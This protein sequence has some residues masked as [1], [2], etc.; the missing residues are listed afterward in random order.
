MKNF[1]NKVTADSANVSTGDSILN[2]IVYVDGNKIFAQVDIKYYLLSNADHSCEGKQKV[3]SYCG[4][5]N[6]IRLPEEKVDTKMWLPY[7]SGMKISGKLILEDGLT[8]FKVVK[9]KKN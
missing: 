2:A 4:C 9:C 7:K 5:Y 6:Y 1:D 3:Y 8:K